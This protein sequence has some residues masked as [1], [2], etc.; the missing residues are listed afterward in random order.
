MRIRWMLKERLYDIRYAYLPLIQKQQQ[1]SIEVVESS[2][3]SVGQV[4]VNVLPLIIIV[5]QLCLF[6]EVTS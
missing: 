4:H 1:Q 2:L 5:V 6:I 3:L